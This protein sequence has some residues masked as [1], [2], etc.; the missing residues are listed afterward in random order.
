MCLFF[1]I[2]EGS[3]KQANN[4]L[5]KLRGVHT[6]NE[7]LTENELSFSDTPVCFIHSAQSPGVFVFACTFV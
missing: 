1:L 3:L 4:N 5:T 7:L 2:L 6:A